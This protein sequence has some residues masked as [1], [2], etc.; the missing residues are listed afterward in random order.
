MCVYVELKGIYHVLQSHRSY[1]HTL[2]M[3]ILFVLHTDLFSIHAHPLALYVF[4]VVN[5]RGEDKR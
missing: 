4:V 5:D 3:L 2:H 1:F